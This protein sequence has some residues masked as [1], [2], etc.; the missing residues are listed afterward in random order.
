MKNSQLQNFQSSFATN[1]TGLLINNYCCSLLL[2]TAR[3]V[4]SSVHQLAADSNMSIKNRGAGGGTVHGVIFFVVCIHVVLGK[5]KG[6]M[7]NLLSTQ[8]ENGISGCYRAMHQLSPQWHVTM[9]DPSATSSSE[10]DLAKQCC[11]R[12]RTSLLQNT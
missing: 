12:L 4:G 5:K 6:K 10:R 11:L 2:A 7:V 8:N 3:M 1:S 9:R